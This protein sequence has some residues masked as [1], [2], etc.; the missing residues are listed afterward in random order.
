M[1]WVIFW[2]VDIDDTAQS[3]IE[4][5]L[6]RLSCRIGSFVSSQTANNKTIRTTHVNSRRIVLCRLVGTGCHIIFGVACHMWQPTQQQHTAHWHITRHAYWRACVR[7]C[8]RMHAHPLKKCTTGV[9][10]SE[11]LPM[12]LFDYILK[13]RFSTGGPRTTRGPKRAARGSAR[14][15]GKIIV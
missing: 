7:V 14:W 4:L 10:N 11:F 2:D 12:C 5:C 9:I 6:K 13:Q 3:S 1:P 8:V 15:Q